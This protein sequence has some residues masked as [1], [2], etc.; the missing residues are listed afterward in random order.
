ML[1]VE[2]WSDGCGYSLQF[3]TGGGV[4]SS[5]CLRVGLDACTYSF[6][7]F[8]ESLVPVPIGIYNVHLSHKCFTII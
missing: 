2:E 4:A 5:P 3:P 7:E 8:I 6:I 1:C